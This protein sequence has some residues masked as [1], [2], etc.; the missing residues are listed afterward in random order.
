[1]DVR[2]PKR[3]GPSVG[4]LHEF[5]R[6]DRND[7]LNSPRISLYTW[8]GRSSANDSRILDRSRSLRRCKLFVS[9]GAPGP[10]LRGFF[11][12]VSICS[13]VDFK[14]FQFASAGQEGEGGTATFPF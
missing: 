6:I 12:S 3:K 5:W 11:Q 13:P 4:S 14:N 8:E 9:L 1:M 2:E 7:R 10:S